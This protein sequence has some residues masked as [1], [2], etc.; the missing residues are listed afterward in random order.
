M[1]ANTMKNLFLAAAAFSIFCTGCVVKE[2]GYHHRDREV[3]EPVEPE[4]E[5]TERERRHH[6]DYVEE[7][8]D[9]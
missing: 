4:V 7:K 2:E 3:I 6:R 9:F 8:V 1:E 5:I